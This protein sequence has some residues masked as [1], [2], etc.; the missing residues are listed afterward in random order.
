MISD[1]DKKKLAEID[2]QIELLKKK[3]ESINPYSNLKSYNNKKFG[4][5][6]SEPHIIDNCP[7]FEIIDGKG[8]DFYNKKLGRIEVKS[9]RLP[10]T[11]VNQCHPNDCDYFLFVFYD[12]DNYEDYL[13]LVPSKDFV[14]KFEPTPQHD[15]HKMTA[16]CFNVSLGT[17]RRK[18]LIKQ[19][20]VTYE[21]L[22]KNYK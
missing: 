15:R 11:T 8:Y 5:E 21:S 6:W 13:F 14:E 4:E 16:S 1:N 3:K 20:K 18:E 9:C 10:A 17:S 2:S 19:Y 22:N 7:I 12:C